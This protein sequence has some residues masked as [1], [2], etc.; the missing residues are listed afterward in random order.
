MKMPNWRV[1]PC[2]VKQVGTGFPVQ[3]RCLAAHG[4]DRQP[5][6]VLGGE[7]LA[8]AWVSPDP[9]FFPPVLMT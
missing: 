1:I 6:Q 3:S 9:N 7:F 4:V 2:Q 8:L 5:T